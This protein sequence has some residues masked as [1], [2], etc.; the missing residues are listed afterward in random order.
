MVVLSPADCKR[1]SMLDCSLALDSERSFS[2]N[3]ADDMGKLCVGWFPCFPALAFR[4]HCVYWYFYDSAD[5]AYKDAMAVQ[6][7]NWVGHPCNSPILAVYSIQSGEPLGTG[8]N[9]NI[10]RRW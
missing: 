9:A 4:N 2:H 5:V 3:C 6:T 1:S 10:R 8:D 7:L